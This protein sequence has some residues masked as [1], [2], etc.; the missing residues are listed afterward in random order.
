MLE[1]ASVDDV[2]VINVQDNTTGYDGNKSRSYLNDKEQTASG[3]RPVRLILE[4]IVLCST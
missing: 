1:I 3:N 4:T 2:A